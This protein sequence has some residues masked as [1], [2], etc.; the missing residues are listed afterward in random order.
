MLVSPDYIKYF[1]I[2]PFASEHTIVFVLL[3]NN[4][5]EY[6]QTIAFFSRV[7]R[8]NELKYKIME[9]NLML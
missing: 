6:E 5:Q 8:D 3:Q 4:N 1:M 2:F 7:F 9:N